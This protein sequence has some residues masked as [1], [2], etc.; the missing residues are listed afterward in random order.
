MDGWSAVKIKDVEFAGVIAKPGAPPPGALPQVAFSGRSNVGKSSLINRLLGRTRHAIARVSNTPGRTQE[1][2]FYRVLAGLSGGREKEFYLVD[3]PGYGYAK[4]PDAIRRRWRP[5]IEG[6]LSGAQGPRG[7]VQL[8]D[9]RHGMTAEDHRM[10]QYLAELGLGTL[11]ALTKAD[12]IG[13]GQLQ[14]ELAKMLRTLGADEEQVVPFSA[15]TGAGRDAL[16]AALEALLDEDGTETG[17][18]GAPAGGGG[19]DG[20]GQTERRPE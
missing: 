18:A 20:N 9:A 4:V 8:I 16:L 2:H 6:Y 19:E 17:G 12:K 10:I 11:Y 14:S 15:K 3:L 13:R 7:V 5:L 1:I